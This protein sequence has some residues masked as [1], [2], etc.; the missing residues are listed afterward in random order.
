MTSTWLLLFSPLPTWSI[1]KTYWFYLKNNVQSDSSHLL[2]HPISSYKISLTCTTSIISL[3][4]SLSLTL[5]LPQS[6]FHRVA[7]V[8]FHKSYIEPYNTLTQ[9]LLCFLGFISPSCKILFFTIVFC[10]QLC[11]HLFLLP[12]C[13]LI[14]SSQWWPFNSSITQHLVLLEG[15]HVCCP[16]CLELCSLSY[17]MWI[18]LN[19]WVTTQRQYS[20]KALSDHLIKKSSL[21]LHHYSLPFYT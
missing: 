16:L 9:T 12:S 3:L 13:L 15:I 8:I 1:R 17:N 18:L 5:G 21:Q 7:N 20:E 6:D 11:S 19:I 10:L 4:V 2:Y 14:I